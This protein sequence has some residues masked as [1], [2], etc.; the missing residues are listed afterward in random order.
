MTV[1]KGM[2]SFRK[3]ELEG[4]RTCVPPPLSFLPPPSQTPSFSLLTTSLPPYS[5]QHPLHKLHV[6]SPHLSCEPQQHSYPSIFS[7]FYLS[8]L[9]TPKSSHHVFLYSLSHPIILSALRQDVLYG[10]LYWVSPLF[11]LFT[12]RP[13]PIPSSCSA[14]SL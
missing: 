11:T 6:F 12:E 9:I 5:H 8:P 7:L 2:E 1:R 4:Y 14:V 13:H 3:R 10:F